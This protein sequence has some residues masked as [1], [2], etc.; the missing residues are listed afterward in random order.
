MALDNDD[1]DDDD[2][3]PFDCWIPPPLHI[4]LGIVNF[5]VKI[6]TRVYYVSS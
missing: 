5:I 6:P 2:D 4:K 3:I 1:D